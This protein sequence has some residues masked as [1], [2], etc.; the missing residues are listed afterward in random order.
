M[1]VPPGV[2]DK[3]DLPIRLRTYWDPK[4]KCMCTWLECQEGTE[5][6]KRVVRRDHKVP[7]CTEAYLS[8]TRA[9]VRAWTRRT[10]DYLGLYWWFPMGATYE[11]I[12]EG[13]GR[14]LIAYGKAPRK[15]FEDGL[16]VLKGQR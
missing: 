14:T 8:A 5:W 9:A 15:A 12:G 1:V 7:Y 10:K 4:A 6:R 2:L 3:P 13:P 16:A 11:V